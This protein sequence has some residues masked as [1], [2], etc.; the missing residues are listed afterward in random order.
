MRDDRAGCREEDGRGSRGRGAIEGQRGQVPGLPPCFTLTLMSARA[1]NPT[2]RTSQPVLIPAETRQNILNVSRA[3]LI[4]WTGEVGEEGKRT[5]PRT[6]KNGGKHPPLSH[7]APPPACEVTC[8]L[9]CA[10]QADRTI[11]NHEPL[12]L[13]PE[14]LGYTS[15]PQ[16]TCGGRGVG[17]G[18]RVGGQRRGEGAEGGRK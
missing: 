10:P 1:F 8:T 17:G 4:T 3:E 11:P 9:F 12:R 13:S 15:E 18:G 16:G 14:P 7:S 5:W 6:E 2:P